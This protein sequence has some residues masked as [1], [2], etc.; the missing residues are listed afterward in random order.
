MYV[1]FSESYISLILFSSHLSSITVS[2]AM[3]ST[4]VIGHDIG[5][6][7]IP[8]KKAELAESQLLQ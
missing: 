3:P 5:G 2:P 1:F 8:A 4:T 6:Q 7:V